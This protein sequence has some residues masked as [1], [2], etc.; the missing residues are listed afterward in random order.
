MKHDNFTGS[1]RLPV[2]TGYPETATGGRTRNVERVPRA[3]VLRREIPVNERSDFAQL[4][5][6]ARKPRN[7]KPESENMSLRCVHSR[8]GRAL[9]LAAAAGLI[10]LLLYGCER[11]AYSTGPTLRSPQSMQ[12]PVHDADV[13]DVEELERMMQLSQ[14]HCA[15][16]QQAKNRIPEPA[17]DL[18]VEVPA[19]AEKVYTGE[20][21]S[22]TGRPLEMWELNGKYGTW[23]CGPE[24]CGPKPEGAK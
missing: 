16:C 1:A 23:S 6:S 22:A 20:P 18:P 5:Q 9:V 21:G 8:V 24:G 15:E 4:R 14:E 3:V 2:Q 10:V 7:Q 11:N 19:V 12:L 13:V 17:I